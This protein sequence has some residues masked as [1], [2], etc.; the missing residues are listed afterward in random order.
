MDAVFI[1]KMNE[2]FSFAEHGNYASVDAEK[3]YKELVNE[4]S[5]NLRKLERD[6]VDT[7]GNALCF[8]TRYVR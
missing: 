8:I 5:T 3:Q 2:A 1:K 4:L 6:K 7:K